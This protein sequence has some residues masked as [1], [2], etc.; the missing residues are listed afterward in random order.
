[1]L[2]A[3][4]LMPRYDYI[5]TECT[6]IFEAR[7]SMD[8][9]APVM[10]PVCKTGLTRRIILSMPATQYNWWNASASE[11]ASGVSKRFRAATE[12]LKAKRAFRRGEENYGNSRTI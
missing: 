6:E 12:N 2:L 4:H 1:M 8:S 11:D 5:C 9:K 7:H 3:E 10:C